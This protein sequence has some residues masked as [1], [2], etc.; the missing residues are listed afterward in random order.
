MTVAELLAKLA[1]AFPAFNAKAAES[2][3][4]VFRARLAKHEGPA[5]AKAYVDTL[6]SFTV[7]RSKALFPVV[8]DFEAHLPS[9]KLDL[10][11]SGGP[12]L[13]FKARGERVRS[14]MAEWRSSQGTRAAGSNRSI[15]RALEFMVEPIAN[16]AAWEQNPPPVRL[17]RA[18]VRVVQQRAISQERVQR[19]GPLGNNPNGAAWWAQIEGICNEWGIPSIYEEWASKKQE[20]REAA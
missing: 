5:L 12:K 14:L 9:G 8:A 11:K 16:L 13:D 2:W 4:P 15:M 3:A 7:A 1:S 10:G 18:Q 19:H 6:S 20:R 17:T